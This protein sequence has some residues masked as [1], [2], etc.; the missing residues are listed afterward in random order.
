MSLD[1]Y[2]EDQFCDHCGRSEEVFW[3][4]MTHN[5]GKMAS[6][7]ELYIP[8]W[9]PSSIGITKAKDLIKPLKKGLARLLVNPERY[10]A[11]NPDNGWGSYDGLVIF[12]EKY[13]KACKTY[14]DARIK[15]SK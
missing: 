5:L 4:N 3:R 2:L 12:V 11:F 6:V 1:V 10:K 7:A 9:D 13:L 14:P 15:I 8:L